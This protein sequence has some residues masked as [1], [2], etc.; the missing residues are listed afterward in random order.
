MK[1]LKKKKR[2]QSM[3]QRIDNKHAQ[4]YIPQT[5]DEMLSYLSEFT[6]KKDLRN[7]INDNT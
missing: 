7:R 2:Y 5:L 1:G 6:Q 3:E 4:T